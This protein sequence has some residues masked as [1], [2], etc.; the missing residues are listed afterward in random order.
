MPFIK[1]LDKFLSNDQAT[2]RTL[3]QTLFWTEKSN[4]YDFTNKFKLLTAENLS[5]VIKKLG[6]KKLKNSFS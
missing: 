4:T 2:A 3:L 1:A 5:I 6:D